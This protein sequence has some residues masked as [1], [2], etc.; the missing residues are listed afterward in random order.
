MEKIDVS[1]IIVNYNSSIMT[2]QCIS[3][4]KEFTREIAIEIIVV[5]N[6]SSDPLDWVVKK[7]QDA[8][9]IYNPSNMG[10]AAA[11]NR[12]H[13]IAR[14]EYI[15][16][17]NNDTLF[18][19]NSLAVLLRYLKTLPYNAIVGCKLLNADRTVQTSTSD[20]DTIWNSIGEN[21][22]LYKAFPRS[23]LFNKYH[24]TYHMGTEPVETDFVK[25][26]FLLCRKN[27]ADTLH[28]FDELFY[29]YSEETDFCFRAKQ[30]GVHV[31]FYPGTSIIHYGAGTTDLMP[32]FAHQHIHLSKM[33][34]FLKNTRGFTKL[35]LL[36]L[37]YLGM[38]IR[39]LLYVGVGI[40]MVDKKQVVR[41][42][43]YFKRL[44]LKI[45]FNDWV[46]DH[47]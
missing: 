22:F 40:I 6:N 47:S 35:S 5:D 38:I 9:F 15:L 33:K 13:S 26:A 27:L 45:G 18:L 44:F 11:N 42:L 17:L 3:S 12:G 37:H 4:V 20:F 43:Y 14:G 30:L 2:D 46:R 19:E 28:G 36:V 25:G 10:F 1:I 32:W 31:M 16:Y 24:L 29:F 8:K 7:H 34:Y 21:L 23:K 41:G 39:G